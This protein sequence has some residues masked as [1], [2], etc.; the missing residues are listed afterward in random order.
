[1]DFL[2]LPYLFISVVLKSRTRTAV[3]LTNEDREIHGFW[4]LMLQNEDANKTAGTNTEITATYI[5]FMY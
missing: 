5:I 1:L 2:P 3:P 4:K